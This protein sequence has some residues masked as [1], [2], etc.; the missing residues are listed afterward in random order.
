MIGEI[1]VSKMECQT[2]QVDKDALAIFA[3]NIEKNSQ[4]TL[5][6]LQKYSWCIRV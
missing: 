1:K 4:A 6:E 5:A 2:L 3:E